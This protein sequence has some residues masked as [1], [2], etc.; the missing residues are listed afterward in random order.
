MEHVLGRPLGSEQDSWNMVSDSWNLASENMPLTCSVMS[1]K[2]VI[3]SGPQF[4]YQLCASR[5][6]D[7]IQFRWFGEESQWGWRW[8]A[9]PAEARPFLTLGAKSPS[10]CQPHTSPFWASCLSPIGVCLE[11][12]P[13]LTFSIATNPQC[14]N[15]GFNILTLR[16]L[17]FK[18]F[19]QFIRALHSQMTRM[20]HGGRRLREAPVSSTS[21]PMA[22]T[23]V[24]PLSSCGSLLLPSPVDPQQSVLHSHHLT[25]LSAVPKLASFLT[26]LLWVVPPL[27]SSHL[28]PT[29][30]TSSIFLSLP[31]HMGSLSK[32]S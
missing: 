11:W 28:L 14:D 30:L 5:N 12:Q 26:P 19:L 24:F 17:S 27:P 3:C 7:Y 9:V 21:I 29:V 20:A 10:W 22:R 18:I 32:K 15:N 25:A 2:S 23:P 8:D 16:T 6:G 4:P 13:G 31:T 1:G